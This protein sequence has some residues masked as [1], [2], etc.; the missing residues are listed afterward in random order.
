MI[1]KVLYQKDKVVNPRRETTQTLYLEAP[2]AIEARALVEANTPYNI[3]FVQELSGNFLDYEKQ[4]PDF[5]LT[6]F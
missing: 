6:E 1:Y 3:E 2:S 4:S 5:K